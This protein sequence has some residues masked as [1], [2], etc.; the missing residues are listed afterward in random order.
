MDPAEAL[1]ATLRQALNL[2]E[3]QQAARYVRAPSSEPLERVATF[4]GAAVCLPVLVKACPGDKV[5]AVHPSTASNSRPTDPV[6]CA[7]RQQEREQ[8]HEL[9]CKLE[10]QLQRQEAQSQV[11]LRLQ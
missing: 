3:A 11:R 5:A 2:G 8:A 7:C 4:L 10:A 1:V 9:A 6:T